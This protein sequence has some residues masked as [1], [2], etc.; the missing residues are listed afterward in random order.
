MTCPRQADVL[1]LGAGPLSEADRQ[2]LRRHADACPSCKDAVDAMNRARAV[3]RGYAQA[4]HPS[5]RVRVWEGLE[6]KRRRSGQ[7]TVLWSA[8]ALAGAL[9]VV[10]IIPR[11][12]PREVITPRL[13]RGH[14]LA[15][16]QTVASGGNLPSGPALLKSVGPARIATAGATLEL[17]A[18]TTLRL[19][20]GGPE[21][22]SGELALS[23]LGTTPIEI[24]TEAVR[25]AA[26]AGRVR[27]WVEG[28][29]AFVRVE[30]GRAVADPGGGA[31]PE[32]LAA[33]AERI[34]VATPAPD[35]GESPQPA[36]SEGQPDPKRDLAKP[37]SPSTRASNA[38]HAPRRRSPPRKDHAASLK[39]AHAVLPAAPK[40]ARA[41]AQ[42][43]L[44][45]RPEPRLEVNAL[46][47]IADAERRSGQLRQALRSYQRVIDHESGNDYAEE[48]LFRQA[49]LHTTLRERS[50]ALSKLEAGD[51]RFADGVLAPERAALKARL[52][53]E[54]G[55]PGAA[56]DAL[57]Q[58]P[59]FARTPAIARLRVEVAEA[60]AQNHRFGRATRLVAPVLE[61]GTDTELR[62]RAKDLMRT[63]VKSTPPGSQPK[64]K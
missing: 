50:E 7:P 2:I 55:L 39:A 57:E 17:S 1:R 13:E 62:R 31:T 30:Q 27:V 41:L 37:P 49:N 44:N 25:I 45:A 40:R 56:A 63:R 23:P 36:A 35:E 53:L 51:Q 4:P 64:T 9:A 22:V 15:K 28:E 18:G 54:A 24:S 60:L 19:S 59:R 10:L 48:A 38:L 52:Y 11:L 61:T 43:V 5:A 29:E 14:I 6:K 58:V 8:A 21:L 16:G 47:L 34:Y 32:A 42:K 26:I 12:F 46:V 3:L 20:A 33:G